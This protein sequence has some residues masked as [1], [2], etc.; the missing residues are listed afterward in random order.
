MQTYILRRMLQ[1]IPLLL[2]LSVLLFFLVRIAPGGPLAQAA[3]NPNISREQLQALRTRLGLDQPLYVQYFHWLR[4]VVV[5]GDLGQSIKS[6]RPVATMIGERI[7]N[8]LLLVGLAFG[9]TLLVALPIGAISA[10]RPY[11]LFDYTVTTFT[12]AGQSVPIYW[13]GLMLILIF[14]VWIDNP[15]TGQPLLPAGG[16]YAAGSQKTLSDLAWHLILPVGALCLTWVAWYSRFFRASMLE[17]LHA[18]YV[19]TARSKGLPERA[20][21]YVHALRNGIMPLV[22]MIALDFPS[23]FAGALFVETI[24][25]WPGMG[26]LFW[27]AARGRDYPVLLGVILINAA[28]IVLCNILADLVYGLVDPR[29]RYES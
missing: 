26:R 7:P 10:Q 5:E 1:A 19:R 16:M 4:A 8:T 27:E 21:T 12:F 13:L 25:S 18:D 23:M 28:L 2:I 17:V 3:R 20:V 14:Y 11:S 29:V 24:F 9:L 15:F 6:N 22:T